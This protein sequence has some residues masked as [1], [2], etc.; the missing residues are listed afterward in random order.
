MKE[1]IVNI[2]KH[3][4]SVFI[5]FW[6][7]YS[8]GQQNFKGVI[9][10]FVVDQFNQ[11]IQ[12]ATV[13]LL[14]TVDSTMLMGTITDEKGEF[15][16][17]QL[18]MGKYLLKISFVGFQ[19]NIQFVNLSNSNRKLNL[20]KIELTRSEE[21]LEELV[22]KGERS[23]YLSL[24]S[25]D[26]VVPD[27]NMLKSSLTTIDLL[28]K[29]PGLK[30]NILNNSVTILG[31]DNVLV[32]IDGIDRSGNINL[33]TLDPKLID[34]IEIIKAPSSKFDSEYTG[35]INII[36]KK[37]NS[38]LTINVDLDYFGLRHNESSAN[39]EYGVSKL[40][41]FLGYQFHYRN[42]S[43]SSNGWDS[44]FSNNAINFN[45]TE[46]FSEN[47]IEIG[48]FFQYG[49]DYFINSK[50]TFNFTG[51]YKI[52]N[53]NRETTSHTKTYH[54]SIL[55]N[56]FQTNLKPE[57]DYIMQNYSLYFEKEFN[58]PE[59]NISFDVNYYQMDFNSNRMISDTYF[60]ANG[61]IL[62]M[63]DRKT[64]NE[65]DKTSL[66]FKVDYTQTLSNTFNYEVGYNFYFRS[67]NNQYNNDGLME[68]FLYDEYR[69]SVYYD[70]YLN[71]IG[72]FSFIN[73]LRIENTNILI[74]DSI[75]DFHTYFVP[76]L[77]AML[78]L[79]ESHTFRTNYKQRLTRPTFI[80]LQP[81]TYQAD[82]I[83][84]YS[85][86]PFLLPQ[87]NDY[88]D[89]SYVFKKEKFFLSST[90]FVNFG[91][92][93]IGKNIEV[94]DN[95]KHISN[96]NVA[97]SFGYGIQFNSS[98]NLFNIL[99]LNPYLDI[100]YQSFQNKDEKNSGHSSS[101]SLS[102]ELT[103]P[104]DIFAGFDLTIPG[105]RYYLQGYDSD[106]F[107]IDAI[108]LGMPVLKEKGSVLIAV[109]NPLSVDITTETFEST[110]DY[111]MYEQFGFDF[112][113]FVVKFSYT[114]H[115]G[116]DVKTLSRQLNMERDK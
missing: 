66:N 96:E 25:K 31:K 34:R 110:F 27:S 60:N 92:N 108:Y 62:Q 80:M 1:R 52:I 10:G 65:D 14:N 95:V 76:V 86:N 103:L 64:I 16:L 22:I 99:R 13:Q 61:S 46:A 3:M 49:F 72:K 75:K 81:F 28:K 77:S 82:S 35:V 93:I 79:N 83:T 4:L 91:K 18:E 106:N 73:G 70:F 38:G 43:Q 50:N 29:V 11:R 36:L 69:N 44:T 45:T 116:K 53:T 84:Y 89:I 39:I 17:E 21:Q 57:G 113:M 101:F 23:S 54:D 56:N 5:I 74:N 115:K 8:F 87:I 107:I 67:F 90:I 68:Y 109:I 33:K 114:F 12:F 100:Y 111:K 94:I 58:K 20:E 63:V 9:S 78:K 97:N 6:G 24:V 102:G 19:P 47:P 15:R 32:L 37:R 98:L 55:I 88:F 48:H 26:V 71:N 85:G 2:V 59:T 30:V 42:H 112:R 41:F 105:K 40:R 51:D 104:K 7:F